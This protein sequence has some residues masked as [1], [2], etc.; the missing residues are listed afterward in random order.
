MTLRRTTAVCTLMLLAAVGC[1]S[2]NGAGGDAA[3]AT[4]ATSSTPT[5]RQ[6]A[7][8]TPPAL[9]AGLGESTAGQH[10][11]TRGNAGFSYEAGP[12]HK[13]LV[14]AVSCQGAGTLKVRLPVLRAEFPLECSAGE[15][16]VTYNQLAMHAAH[17]AGTVEVTAPSGVT[18]AVTVGRGDIAEPDP[19]G[20]D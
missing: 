6:T 3:P 11:A 8:V 16:A 15:P 9:D 7:G 14:V 10:G 2:G 1:T 18:W 4:P 13:A 5:A 19:P 12:R 17:K 20:T